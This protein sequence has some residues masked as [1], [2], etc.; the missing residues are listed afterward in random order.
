VEEVV[1]A[2]AVIIW[3]LVRQE[4]VVVVDSLDKASLNSL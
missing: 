1:V 3:L 4:L 2:V